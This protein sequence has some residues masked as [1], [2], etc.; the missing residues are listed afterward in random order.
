LFRRIDQ[1]R[2]PGFS[3]KPGFFFSHRAQSS[4]KPFLTM[5]TADRNSEPPFPHRLLSALVSLETWQTLC[6]LTV[7]S[8]VRLGQASAAIL[9]SPSGPDSLD[10]I[11][12]RAVSGSSPQL[13]QISIDAPFSTL[14][15][16]SA[17]IDLVAETGLIGGLHIQVLPWID[18]TATLVV[19]MPDPEDSA[20]NDR[21]YGTLA[22]IG[23]QLLSRASDRTLLLP[24]HS[25][26]EA[27]AEY[28]A[29]AGHEINNPLASIIGQTQLLLKVEQATD[30]RQAYETIG[31]QAWRIRDMIGNSML[32]AR[33]PQAQR[34]KMNLVEITR[35]TLVPLTSTAA[36]SDVEIRLASTSDQIEMEA[37]RTQMAAAIQHLVRNSLES[38]KSAG[39]PGT[40][41]VTLRDDVPGSVELSIVDDG[42]GI[43]SPEVRRHLFNPFFS[44]RSAGRG[45]GFG[46]CLT[47]QITRMHGGMILHETP[48]NGGAAFHLALKTTE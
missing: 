23:R 20:S 1:N 26:L 29:G 25:T 40:I 37:D 28:A 44:G 5:T 38:I 43:D 36:E 27:M 45:L 32:F 47:W 10:L 46:L 31:A 16:Q 12:C 42:P 9:I 15:N 4:G 17:V 6:V 14:L 35:Q 22:A 34:Q 30:R 18:L 24:D 48:A 21:F 7:E 2:E 41:S 13:S 8:W 33:P 39:R 11:C 19:Q 3:Q